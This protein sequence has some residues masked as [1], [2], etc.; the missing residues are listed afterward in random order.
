MLLKVRQFSR[1][2]VFSSLR[3][4]NEAV[5]EGGVPCTPPGYSSYASLLGGLEEFPQLFVFL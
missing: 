4:P 5:T 3:P 2:G 1:A